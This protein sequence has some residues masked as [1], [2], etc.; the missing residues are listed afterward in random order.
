MIY[1]SICL[2]F[3]IVLIIF[4]GLIFNWGL[5]CLLN[6][7]SYFYEIE[8]LSVNSSMIVI[9]LLIDWMSCFFLSFV[10]LISSLVI[11]YRMDYIHG[12]KYINRFIILVLIF[13]LSMILLII[14][15]NLIRIL[16]G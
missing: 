16:L 6:E 1:L 9:T 10:R 15:P 2:I 11:F 12:D 5:Y 8:L 7:I 3:F 13:V 14:S 4:S